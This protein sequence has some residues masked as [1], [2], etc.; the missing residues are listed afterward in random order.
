MVTTRRAGVEVK[1]TP[2]APQQTQ[3]KSAEQTQQ[4]DHWE[5]SDRLQSQLSF[6]RKSEERISNRK[7]NRHHGQ[8]GS[9][10]SSQDGQGLTSVKVNRLEV[11]ANFYESVHCDCLAHFLGSIFCSFMSSPD[12]LM[13]PIFTHKILT[14]KTLYVKLGISKVERN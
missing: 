7:I 9:L 6:H 5:D 14:R 11:T 4:Q 8:Q 2:Q 3:K 12:E 1:S 10:K 13:L